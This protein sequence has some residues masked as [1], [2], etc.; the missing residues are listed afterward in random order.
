MLENTIY[1]YYLLSPQNKEETLLFVLI[2]NLCKIDASRSFNLHGY[3]QN[4][5]KKVQSAGKFHTFSSET[6]CQLSKKDNIKFNKW[7]AGIMD[8]DGSFDLR[9]SKSN[10]QYRL[11][12]IRIKLHKR[13]LRILKRIQNFLHYG[14]ILEIK[15]KPYVMY[16]ISSKTQMVDF[17]SRIN[18]NIRLKVSSFQ[19]ALKYLNLEF[20]E[21]DYNILPLDPYFSGLIDTDGSIVFNYA[22]NRIECN[23][24]LKYNEYSKRLNLDFVIPKYKPYVLLRKKKSSAK[25]EKKYKS[26]AFK[27]Q[28]V[29]GMIL[30][31]DYFIKNRLYSDFKFYRITQ[32]IHFLP[33]RNFKKSQ[34]NSKEW[35]LYRN[36]LINWIRYKNPFWEKT[37]FIRKFIDL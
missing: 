16:V 8:G 5:N 3:N 36:F 7:L 32:I 1:I 28:T 27:F 24:E 26:I 17:C 11:A 23:L 15:K 14:R 35:S 20:K 21:A 33:I 2:P 37:P 13:D 12:S 22:S 9:K 18:L 6:I 19:K 4:N 10:N 34:K 25:G 30:L 31:Y 29:K